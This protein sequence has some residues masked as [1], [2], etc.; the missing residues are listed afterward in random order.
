MYKTNLA[1]PPAGVEPTYNIIREKVLVVDVAELI[2][3]DGHQLAS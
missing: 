1:S 2:G 3:H